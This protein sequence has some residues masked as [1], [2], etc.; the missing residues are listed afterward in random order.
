MQP[1]HIYTRTLACK[2]YADDKVIVSYACTLRLTVTIFYTKL[3]MQKPPVSLRLITEFN[4]E[5]DHHC[6]LCLHFHEFRDTEC[7]HNNR[8][9]R[10]GYSESSFYTAQTSNS[11]LSS[12]AIKAKVSTAPIRPRPALRHK[13]SP[14]AISLRELRAKHSHISL[15]R[16][17]QSDEQLQ[18][19]YESQIISYLD[20]PY[21]NRHFGHSCK[22][23][24]Q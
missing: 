6:S 8:R 2:T 13:L 23:L 14:T 7:K 3:M 9:P 16:A 20:S 19:L 10:S 21:A 4:E 5:L 1:F 24:E 11:S 15:V 12:R 17:R 18:Q 22:D